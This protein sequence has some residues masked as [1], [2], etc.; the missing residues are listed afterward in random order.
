MAVD[1][2]AAYK[3]SQK[4]R[5]K[6]KLKKNQSELEKLQSGSRYK[7]FDPGG[8]RKKR[9][10][11][12]LKK[13]ILKAKNEPAYHESQFKKQS[14]KVETSNP[15]YGKDGKH[16]KH[17]KA[18]QARVEANRK[19]KEAGAVERQDKMTP[20]QTK[21]ALE[22]SNKRQKEAQKPKGKGPVKDAKEYGKTVKEHA[23][24]KEAEDRKEWEKKTRNSP[25]RRSGAF[26]DEELWEKQ[27]KHRQ[28]KA[29]RKS[30]K[31]KKNKLKIASPMDMD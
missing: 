21:K 29:D 24:K 2:Y 26:S 14:K 12:S 13:N 16:E 8:F 27:K 31:K 5:T 1:R 28:W 6:K 11:K 3:K 22:I 30:G 18:E 15:N 17:N 20:E 25:A 19:A 23:A 4:K 7:L 10:M 9:R